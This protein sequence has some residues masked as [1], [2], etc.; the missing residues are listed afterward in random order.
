M[1]GGIRFVE[2]V[3]DLETEELLESLFASFAGFF[4]DLTIETFAG[5]AQLLPLDIHVLFV[6]LLVHLI[7]WPVRVGLFLF[8]LLQR[9]VGELGLLVRPH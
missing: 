2:E 4:L 9:D 6:L 8:V 3:I 5:V 7:L 1:G